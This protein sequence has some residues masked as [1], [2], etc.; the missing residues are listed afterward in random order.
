[1]L[2]TVYCSLFT[3]TYAKATAGKIHYSLLAIRYSLNPPI[4]AHR[5]AQNEYATPAMTLKRMLW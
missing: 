3:P 2:F 4:N 5:T 1:M